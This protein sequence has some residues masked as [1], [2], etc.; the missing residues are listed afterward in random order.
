MSITKKQLQVYEF[1]VSFLKENNYA[2]TQVEIKNHFG[3][4]SLGSVQ[5]YLKYLR[6]AGYI[7]HDTNAVRGLTPLKSLDFHSPDSRESYGSQVSEM[8]QDDAIYLPLL[9]NVAAG[10]PIESVKV[11]ESL[12]VPRY[13]LSTKGN[14]YLLKVKGDSMIEDG[15]FNDDILIIRSQ[16]TFHQGQTVVALISNEATVK[17]IY[18]HQRTDQGGVHKF[19]ELRP[20]NSNLEPLFVENSQL[21]VQGVVAGLFRQY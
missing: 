7:D 21:E 9:G 12:L 20:A 17:K 8:E 2:P 4:K 16:K 13:L 5:D 14:H 10:K 19:Y 3:L 18:S 15:I 6:E 11:N 1:I